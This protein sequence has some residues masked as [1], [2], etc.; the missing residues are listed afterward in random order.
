MKSI[1]NQRII[2][3]IKLIECNQSEHNQYRSNQIMK[4][5]LYLII[6]YDVNYEYFIL[7]FFLE[8]FKFLQSLYVPDV[9][10]K[11]YLEKLSRYL[12]LRLF[13][14]LSHFLYF[15]TFFRDS[16]SLRVPFLARQSHA[17]GIFSRQLLYN[18]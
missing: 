1:I 15:D 4:Q 16:E 2:N 6:T 10:T 17:L 11:L 14:K 18:G 12:V 8:N 7:N 5:L 13:R 3:R 9:P